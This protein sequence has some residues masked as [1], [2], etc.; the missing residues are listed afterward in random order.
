M[1]IRIDDNNATRIIQ[2]DNGL[3]AAVAAVYAKE[4]KDNTAIATTKAAEAAA[5]AAAALV[6]EGLAN[7]DAIA[8]AADRVQTGLDAIATAADAVATAGD[9]VQTGLDAVATAADRVQTGLD[10]T[11]TGLDVLTT[12]ADKA[13][14]ALDVAATAA[15]VVLTHADVVLTHADVAI[16]NADVVTTNA[17]VATTNADVVLTG[18][19]R[20]A[21]NADVVSAQDILT[22]ITT[23][24]N[25]AA[26]VKTVGAGKDFETL[27]LAMDYTKDYTK[28]SFEFVLYASFA[29]QLDAAHTYE[30]DYKFISDNDELN[31]YDIDFTGSGFVWFVGKFKTAKSIRLLNTG[32]GAYLGFAYQSFVEFRGDIGNMVLSPVQNTV[33]IFRD[34]A[35]IAG[36][37]NAVWIYENSIVTVRDCSLVE[38]D[39][40]AYSLSEVRFRGT[41]VIGGASAVSMHS[42]PL[43][44]VKY[45][46]HLTIESNLKIQHSTLGVSVIEGCY[47][48]GAEY[49]IFDNVTTKYNI[50]VNELQ[51]TG[52]YISDSVSPVL[53]RIVTVNETSQATYTPD[54]NLGNHFEYTLTQNSTIA[55]VSNCKAGQQGTIILNQ[56]VTGGWTAD[57]EQFSYEFGYVGNP[58]IGLAANTVNVFKYTVIEDGASPSIFMEFVASYIKEGA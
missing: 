30:N 41:S 5:S 37:M 3:N 4:S 40:A 58:A 47:C 56:D 1:L 15:D 35:T 25:R 24:G 17:N 45:S 23:E 11:Q 28:G 2:A 39:F 12:T 8:T 9:R 42:N 31:V 57:F 32:T 33:M 6:S 48:R 46:A 18:L 54:F 55:Q 16:T 36:E 38:T 14:T 44:G 43:A 50:P 49:I 34:M 10:R 51:D 13:Q 20:V 26:V 21:T 19:D 7:A 52:S 22:T 53:P 29:C 27:Q